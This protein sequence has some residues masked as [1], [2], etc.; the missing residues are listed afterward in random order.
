MND[1]SE[2]FPATEAKS[3][4]ATELYVV[5]AKCQSDAIAGFA[6]QDQNAA[7]M[8]TGPYALY[9]TLEPLILAAPKRCSKP[10]NVGLVKEPA[11][12]PLRT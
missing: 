1:L 4:N 12:D 6:L 8:T 11:F 9:R 7:P 3:T 5:P 10:E 2:T